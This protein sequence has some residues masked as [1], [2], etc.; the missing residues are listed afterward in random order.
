MN[1]HDNADD[2]DDDDSEDSDD[3]SDDDES[4]FLSATLSG[5]DLATPSLSTVTTS[6]SV[7]IDDD[8]GGSDSSD[9]DDDDDEVEG[10]HHE[11]LGR[12]LQGQHRMEKAGFF[13][14][15]DWIHDDLHM[16]GIDF[17]KQFR[18]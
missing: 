18:P 6:S 9:D 10:D 13:P 2:T 15:D 3:D 11:V 14:L 16:P 8:D 17:M 5:A 12:L 7:T 1:D 4:E